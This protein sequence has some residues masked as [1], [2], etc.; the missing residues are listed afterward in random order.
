MSSH[1]TVENLSLR[2]GSFALRGINLT[3]GAGEILVLLGANGAGKSLTLE[4]IAGLY[5]A[6]TGRIVIA[7]RDVTHLP[8]ERR[9][10]S[11][12]FQNFALFPHLS[13]AQN[14]QIAA[15]RTGTPPQSNAVPLGD[16]DA[17]LSC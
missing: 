15:R 14:V 2:L 9:H 11:L 12:V 6:R 8:P 3:V 13:V 17:L 16:P 1:A 7:G 4:T 10:V 5:R